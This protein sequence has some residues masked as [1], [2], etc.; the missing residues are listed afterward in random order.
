MDGGR[1]T[2]EDLDEGP[3]GDDGNASVLAEVQQIR[4]PGNNLASLAR[5][6]SGH[7]PRYGGPLE[8]VDQGEFRRRGPSAGQGS[9]IAI[10][11]ACPTMPFWVPSPDPES[12]R[13]TRSRD[14]RATDYMFP[15]DS[16]L[17]CAR[18]S[19]LTL[20]GD[21]GGLRV[22]ARGRVGPT[23]AGPAGSLPGRPAE[24]APPRKRNSDHPRLSGLQLRL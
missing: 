22:A 18:Y 15:I 12:E 8:S 9:S 11:R 20:A 23:G 19:T 6:V 13:T 10:S 21:Q 4:V 5:D 14:N 2:A 16:R 1:L 3:S 24:G 17:R 7:V